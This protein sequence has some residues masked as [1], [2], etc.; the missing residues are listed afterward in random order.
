MKTQASKEFEHWRSRGLGGSALSVHMVFLARRGEE[1]G[2]G[3]ACVMMIYDV[4][5]TLEQNEPW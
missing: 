1:L 2:V 4:L 3:V 5:L